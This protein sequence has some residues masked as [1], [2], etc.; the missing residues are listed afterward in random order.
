MQD[1]VIDLS[2]WNTVEDWSEIPEDG[3]IGV[4]HKATEG[5][6][7]VDDKYYGRKSGAL[8]QGLLWGAYH[9]LRP[10][11]QQAHAKHF[12]ATAGAIDIYAADHEDPDVSLAELKEFL[13]AVYDLT[14]VRPIVYSGHVIKEQVGS[15]KDDFLAEHRLWLAQYSSS[16]SWPKQIWPE[17]W[18]WQHTDQ[19][20]CAG[21]D[22]PVD[23]NFYD[24]EP[25]E[26]V[27]DWTGE[28]SA[29]EPVEGAEV[30]IR[31]ETQGNVKVNIITDD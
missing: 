20:S 6:S 28:E 17:W 31:I 14:G 24:G 26:L 25:D 1:L 3:I 30:T 9:F 10:G 23:L 22:P 2:H 8:E 29:P 13:Q 12:V 11:D 21:C 4:I 19:G 5:A 18:L 7:Y 15:N 16:P 27:A